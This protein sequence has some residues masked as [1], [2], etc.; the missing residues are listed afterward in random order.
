M[1]RIAIA[2]DHPLITNSI[3]NILNHTGYYTVCGTY[4]SGES[5]LAG[6][7]EV[8]PEVLILDYHLPDQNGAQL[9]RSIAY[10][11]PGIKILVLTGF[12]KPGLLSEMLESGCSGYLLKTSAKTDVLLEALQTI[13]KGGIYID[14]SLKEIFA[15]NLHRTHA[16]Q[17]KEE[18]LRLTKR[19]LEILGL[20]VNELSSQEIADRLFISKKTVD[21]HRSSIIMKTGAKNNFALMKIAIDLKLI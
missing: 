7:P 11:Y 4:E 19:E 21:N 6:L 5:L 14:K 18:G 1:T 8:M 13:C 12:D 15:E 17:I 2:D 9:A 3:E 20:I 16:A 10:Y